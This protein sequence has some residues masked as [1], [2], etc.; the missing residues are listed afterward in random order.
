VAARDVLWGQAVN[1]YGY[2]TVRDALGLGIDRLTVDKLGSAGSDRAGRA[3][4]VP[5]PAA[6]RNRVRPVHAG[7]TVDR[8]RGRVPEP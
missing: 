8:D 2:V 3:R 5:V 6:S 4:R 7:R 1:Q